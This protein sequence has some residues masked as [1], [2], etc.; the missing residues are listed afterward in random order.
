MWGCFR[1]LHI[2]GFFRTAT[3]VGMVL[4]CYTTHGGMVHGCYI[5]Y[6]GDGLGLQHM[7]GWFMAVRFVTCSGC[8]GTYLHFQFTPSNM[9]HVFTLKPGGILRQSWTVGG[10]AGCRLGVKR[11]GGGVYES[12]AKT[13][14]ENQ[15]ELDG[16]GSYDRGYTCVGGG[17]GL[18]GWHLLQ[19]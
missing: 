19:R 11:A 6:V 9:L 13:R 10:G 16:P 12:H 15:P 14:H 8:S 4:G 18:I 5:R 17:G 1:L 7:W 3:H 2:W